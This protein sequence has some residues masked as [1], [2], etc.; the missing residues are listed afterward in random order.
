MIVL[1]R[2]YDVYA[3]VI[4]DHGDLF[5]FSDD[6]L[7]HYCRKIVYVFLVSSNER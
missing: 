2:M 1:L 3:V 6:G 4:V 7:L 5:K